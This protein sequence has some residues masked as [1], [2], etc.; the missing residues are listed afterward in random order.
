M[1][2]RRGVLCTVLARHSRPSLRFLTQIGMGHV[3]PTFLNVL[4][5]DL[6]E[7]LGRVQ[8]TRAAIAL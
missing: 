6:A 5:P 2:V 3:S 8:G 4:T 7:S 1:C